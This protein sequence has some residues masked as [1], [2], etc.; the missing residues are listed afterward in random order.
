LGRA[1]AF[2][3][4]L[5]ITIGSVA[6]RALTGGAPLFPGL[7]ALVVL[8]GLHWVFSA[9]ARDH[10]AFSRLIKGTPTPLIQDGRVNRKALRAAHMSNDDLE[11]DLR[12]KGIDDPAQVKE[13]RLERNG[14]L[15][16]VKNDHLRDGEQ[17]FA[18]SKCHE[19]R[20]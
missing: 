7:V 8:V 9:V 4:I 17:A 13:A 10:P 2:D 18:L 15:S 5:V 14:R 6:A 1:T 11:E 3:V 16:A 19:K 12:E 20:G